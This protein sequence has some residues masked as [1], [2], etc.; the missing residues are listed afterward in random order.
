MTLVTLVKRLMMAKATTWH[1]FF[2]LNV[3]E[4]NGPPFAGCQVRFGD[5]K[6][7]EIWL[8]PL[9][10]RRILEHLNSQL[11]FLVM[12]AAAQLRTGRIRSKLQRGIPV[13]SD[14]RLVRRYLK[15]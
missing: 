2:V 4:R 3:R 8:L 6:Q 13:T 1:E 15:S 9:Q 10:A 14:T 7:Y 12:A 5:G 11:A